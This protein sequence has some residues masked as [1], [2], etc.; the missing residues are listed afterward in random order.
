MPKTNQTGLA[1]VHN[2]YI[3]QMQLQEFMETGLRTPKQVE[4]A[5]KCLKEFR[6]LLEAVDPGYMG[7]EDVLESLHNMQEKMSERVKKRSSKKK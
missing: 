2:L 6:A 3:A 7:G 5:K 4:A 1:A